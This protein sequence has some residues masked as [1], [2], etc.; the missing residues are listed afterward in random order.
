MLILKTIRILPIEVPWGLGWDGIA[1]M[2]AKTRFVET[3]KQ[4]RIAQPLGDLDPLMSSYPDRQSAPSRRCSWEKQGL[5]FQLPGQRPQSQTLWWDNL[6]RNHPVLTKTWLQNGAT[7]LTRRKRQFF[8]SS[9][10]CENKV[11]IPVRRL[12][13]RRLSGEWSIFSCRRMEFLPK[14]IYMTRFTLRSRVTFPS[15]E[16]CVK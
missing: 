14:N 12:D 1:M 10:Y 16:F 11:D 7:S 4:Y 5:S 15:R 8:S 2:R 3:R 9:S 6:W 13:L